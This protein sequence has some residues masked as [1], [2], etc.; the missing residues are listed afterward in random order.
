[1]KSKYIKLICLATVLL[2]SK[3]F[4]TNM[5]PTAGLQNIADTFL[6]KFK[7]KDHLTGIAITL[8]CPNKNP[9]SVFSGKINVDAKSSDINDKNLWQIGSITKSFTSI[10]ILQLEEEHKFDINNKNRTGIKSTFGDVFKKYATNEFKRKKYSNWYNVT[11]EQ[12]MNMTAG[13]PEYFDTDDKYRSDFAKNP[14]K[15][16]SLDDILAYEKDKKLDFAPGTSW[17][18][19]DTGYILLGYIIKIV[20]DNEPGFEI[21]KRVI[22]KI[23]LKNTYYVIDD[24]RN[25]YKIRNF[26]SSDISQ[27][28]VHG[29]YWEDSNNHPKLFDSGTDVTTV[30]LSSAATAGSIISTTSDIDTFVRKLFTTNELLSKNQLNKL[31]KFVSMKTGALV[32]YPKNTD[33]W[34]GL[35]IAGVYDYKNKKTTEIMYNGETFGY[36]SGYRYFPKNGLIVT[37]MINTTKDS[38]HKHIKE[39]VLN[40]AINEYWDKCE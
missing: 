5:L 30:S 37:A 28:L 31:K 35:G 36:I 1:M 18:Y 3:T 2:A 17:N 39:E 40:K 34:F 22:D 8:S 12:L 38:S 14:N 15:F 24:P 27:N 11:I 23:H 29:Y 9:I 13:V 16:Y 25:P 19:S 33:G 26:S 21:K 7:N 32:K 10:V 6:G 20:T 4:A